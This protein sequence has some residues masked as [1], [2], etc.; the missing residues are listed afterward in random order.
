MG[1]INVSVCDIEL[2]CAWKCYLN[3]KCRVR[4]NSDKEVKETSC[5][6]IERKVSARVHDI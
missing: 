3:Q 1:K 2:Q 6:T 5:V 4:T